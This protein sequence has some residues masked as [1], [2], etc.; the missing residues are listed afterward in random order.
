MRI[1]AAMAGLVAAT[2]VAAQDAVQVDFRNYIPGLLD[3]PVF[4]PDG[5]TRLR[6]AG[7]TFE[8][9]AVLCVSKASGDPPFSSFSIYDTRLFQ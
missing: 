3:A 5:V 7:T 8:P 2:L 6:S 9:Q 1:L 4:Y